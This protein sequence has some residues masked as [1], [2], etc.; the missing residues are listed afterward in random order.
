MQ[1]NPNIVLRKVNPANF[2]VDIT[3]SYNSSEESLLEIDEMGVAIWNCIK[4]KMSRS[5]I[6]SS[7][8]S[9]LTDEKD[10]DFVSMV[11]RDVNEFLDLL[12]SYHCILED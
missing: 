1:R 9:L 3:K 6:V 11:S 10:E 12:A 2:L 4:P 7:F 5:D 8:L